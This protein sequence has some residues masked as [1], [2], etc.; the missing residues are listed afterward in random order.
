MKQRGG[1][2][3]GKP[4]SMEPKAVRQR[5]YRAKNRA[6]VRETARA[7]YA[8]STEKGWP[9][10]WAQRLIYTARSNSRKYDRGISITEL[11]IQLLWEQQAGR[12]YWT[13]V[14]LS[15]KRKSPWVVSLDRLDNDEG[16]HPGNVV[17]CCWLANRARGNL[18][19]E[20]FSDAL[21]TL[22][23]ALG[24]NVPLARVG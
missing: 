5:E 21:G 12:C 4:L 20:E 7:W 6:K 2:V 16:Y 22:A 23:L 14:E 8:K 18:S 13:G 11:T 3:D 1:R 10:N 15:T 19:V 24:E 9:G 17:L